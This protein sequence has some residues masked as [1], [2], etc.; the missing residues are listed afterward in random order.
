MIIKS[1][2]SPCEDC[3]LLVLLDVCQ[4]PRR[5]NS[6]GS[7]SKASV[8]DVQYTAWLLVEGGKLSLLN[9]VWHVDPGFI[10]ATQRKP[11][12]AS[13]WCM[14][15][16]Y[17]L[18]GRWFGTFLFFHILGMS[19]SQLTF[20]FFRGVGIPPT[21]NIFTVQLE[22]PQRTRDGMSKN[23]GRSRSEESYSYDEF[24]AIS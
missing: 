16:D 23:R 9:I 24:L 12:S 22:L 7:S 18:G 14:I 1:R 5:P 4:T 2:S 19:S 6:C 3:W 8:Q 17:S 21:R 10:Y 13:C 11:S 15:W 20:I